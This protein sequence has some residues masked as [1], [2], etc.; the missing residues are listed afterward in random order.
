VNRRSSSDPIECTLE[1]GETTAESVEVTRLAGETIH[2][3][4]TYETPDRV[5]PETDS[6]AIGTES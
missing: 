1:A 4:N 3:E 6:A 2:A 5:A